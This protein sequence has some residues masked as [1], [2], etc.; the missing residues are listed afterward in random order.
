MASPRYQ[1]YAPCTWPDRS[2]DDFHQVSWDIHADHKDIWADKR[3]SA[4]TPT[5]SAHTVSICAKHSRGSQ[6]NGATQ[7][8][9]P[10]SEL[11]KSARIDAPLVGED[12]RAR[13]FACTA[14][15]R[16]WAG[17]SVGTAADPESESAPRAGELAG[18]TRPRGRWPFRRRQRHCVSRVTRVCP[19]PVAREL[20]AKR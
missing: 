2:T 12:R 7:L 8:L 5:I 6:N 15:C 16:T 19:R 18:P 17:L 3:I 11:R 14:T 10:A 20:S 9:Q 1:L 13:G 4:T